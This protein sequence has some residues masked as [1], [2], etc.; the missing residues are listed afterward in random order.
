MDY[1]WSAENRLSALQKRFCILRKVISFSSVFV[2]KGV[3][4]K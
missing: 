4:L 2:S 3:I 1:F